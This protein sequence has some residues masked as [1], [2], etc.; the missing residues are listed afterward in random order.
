MAISDEDLVRQ[1]ESI[2]QIEPPDMREPVM[3]RV[4]AGFSRP[5]DRLK[6]VLTPRRVLVGLAWAAA[7]VIVIGV[8]IE[9]NSFPWQHSSAT[10]VPLPADQWPVVARLSVPQEARLTIRRSGDRFAIQPFT[11]SGEP[12]SVAWDQKKLSMTD[13]LS[14]TKGPEVV[15]LQRRPGASGS[16]V[17][18]LNVGGR[19]ILKTSISVE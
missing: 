6:P 5:P 4:R 13:V 19:E 18:Q 12:V 9:R 11:I 14:D 17:I 2:P 3:A 16:A 1:L 7:L 10:M 8:V 15:I